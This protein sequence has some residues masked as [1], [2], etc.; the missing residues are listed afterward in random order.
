MKKLYY[1]LYRKFKGY[2][3]QEQVREALQQRTADNSEKW[4]VG[5]LYVCGY[6][7]KEISEMLTITRERVRII[8]NVL[9]LRAK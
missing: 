8:L 4:R 7:I 1:S 9:V 6:T 2:P 3:C 5:M